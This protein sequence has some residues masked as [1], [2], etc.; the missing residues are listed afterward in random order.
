MNRSQVACPD[1]P[2]QSTPGDITQPKRDST[3]ALATK[4]VCHFNHKIR[5]IS[6]VTAGGL[7]P[8]STANYVLYI[9][10]AWLI[11]LGNQ[12]QNTDTHFLKIGKLRTLIHTVASEQP[13]ATQ[14]AS[15]AHG[16]INDSTGHAL[17]WDWVSAGLVA[18]SLGQPVARSECSMASRL[19]NSVDTA[20]C[21]A[22]LLIGT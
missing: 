12:P 3:V 13:F 15:P 22:K 5:F 7:G 18:L 19:D 21:A 6:T 11:K 10:N 1:L 4:P 16:F 2:K 8:I 9:K 14:W 20:G 17:Q